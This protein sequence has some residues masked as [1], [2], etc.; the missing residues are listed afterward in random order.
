MIFFFF[1][2]GQIWVTH[3]TIFI[4]KNKNP[5]RY[6]KHSLI[7]KAPVQKLKYV[8]NMWIEKNSSVK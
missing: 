6:L 2:K 7:H 5:K 1:L 4:G 3:S 8:Q